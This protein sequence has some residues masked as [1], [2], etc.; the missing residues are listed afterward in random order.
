MT[1]HDWLWSSNDDYGSGSIVGSENEAVGGNFLLRML[2]DGAGLSNAAV[3]GAPV[4]GQG[5]VSGAASRGQRH[6][7]RVRGP[8][9]LG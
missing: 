9:T 6:R 4:G 7:V 2:V 1:G 3:A 5:A 8:H